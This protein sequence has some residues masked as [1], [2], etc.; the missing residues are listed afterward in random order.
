MEAGGKDFGFKVEGLGDFIA[1]KVLKHSVH[2]AAAA[3]ALT[4]KYLLCGQ[5]R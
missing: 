4:S 2:T 1:Y 5:I 3:A